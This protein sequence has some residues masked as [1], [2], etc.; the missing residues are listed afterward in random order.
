MY[1]L[2]HYPLRSASEIC[3]KKEDKKKKINF[4]A[5]FRDERLRRSYFSSYTRKYMNLHKNQIATLKS[6]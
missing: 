2:T 1:F 3:E 5:I 6:N 4:V